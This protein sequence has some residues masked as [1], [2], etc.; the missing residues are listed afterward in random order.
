[1]ANK[2][3]QLASTVQGRLRHPSPARLPA[4][5]EKKPS[6][7]A[8]ELSELCSSFLADRG[9]LTTHHVHSPQK[10]SAA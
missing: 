3:P 4:S 9:C 5:F 7:S 6:Q 1:M 10:E 8:H 2:L